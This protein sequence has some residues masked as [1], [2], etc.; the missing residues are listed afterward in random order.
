[1]AEYLEFLKFYFNQIKAKHP[2]WSAKFISKIVKWS[3][4]KL[5]IDESASKEDRKAP[6][7]KKRMS[8]KMAFRRA[9]SYSKF[10]AT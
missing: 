1:M 4:K 3:R 5:K 10:K 8:G 7:N 6:I 9:Y 2:N